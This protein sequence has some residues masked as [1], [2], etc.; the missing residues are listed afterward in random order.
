MKREWKVG[1]VW[2]DQHGFVM[3]VMRIDKTGVARLFFLRPFIQKKLFKQRLIP[4]TWKRK[5][6]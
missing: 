3:V 6:L 1:D 2:K 4:D 5:R